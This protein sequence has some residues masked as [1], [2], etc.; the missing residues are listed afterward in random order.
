MTRTAPNRIKLATY[1][2]VVPVSARY[3][4]V[5]PLWHINNVAIAQYFEEGRVSGL[6]RM[7]GGERM[8][9]TIE[10]LLIAHQTIDYL[11]EASYPGKLEVGVGMLRIGRSS[12]TIGLG[13]FQGATC[14]SVSDAVMVS[15]DASGPARLAEE[16]R[17]RL[18]KWLLPVHPAT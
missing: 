14:V 12:F 4:D 9:A 11:H 17:D 3:G 8:P 1:P 2:S 6:R 5:D 16:A 13:L 15:A 7:L 10:R 18:E